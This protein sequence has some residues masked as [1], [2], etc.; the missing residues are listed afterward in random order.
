[1]GDLTGCGI[2]I[3]TPDVLALWSESFDYELPRKNF[4]HGV[5]KDCELNGKII[6]AEILEEGYGARASNLQMYDCISKDILHRWALPYVPDS[7]L[8]H[9]Q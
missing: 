9:G 4:L 3:C 2:V 6:S 1:S 7:N 5:L 8:L